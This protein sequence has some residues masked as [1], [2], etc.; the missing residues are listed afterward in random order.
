M[1]FG[2]Y[3]GGAQGSI[4]AADVDEF[5]REVLRPWNL[6]KWVEGIPKDALLQAL[7]VMLGRR[8]ELFL[9]PS[10]IGMIVVEITNGF[11]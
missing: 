1:Q 7:Q 2:G 9:Y 10:S 5:I 6:R 3:L 11:P 4:A 8:E